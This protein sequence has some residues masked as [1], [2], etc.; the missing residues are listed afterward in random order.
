MH[1]DVSLLIVSQRFAPSAVKSCLRHLSP[2]LNIAPSTLPRISRPLG[3]A[4]SLK[5]IPFVTAPFRGFAP[6]S[7]Q[8]STNVALPALSPMTPPFPQARSAWRGILYLQRRQ[9][10]LRPYPAS[11]S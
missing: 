4:G 3:F 6:F 10:D 2:S 1:R 5:R 9:L 11:S 8:T 7:L